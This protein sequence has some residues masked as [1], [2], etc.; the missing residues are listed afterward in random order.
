MIDDDR[1]RRPEDGLQ[2]GWKCSYVAVWTLFG[3]LGAVWVQLCCCLAVWELFGCSCIAVWTLLGAVWELFGCCLDAVRELS[4]ELFGCWSG[5]V[6]GTVWKLL[7]SCLDA[8]R[9]L[10]ESCSG[11]VL[12]LFRRVLVAPR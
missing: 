4:W 1:L 5:A 9:V 11:A 12:K 7:G 2:S 3:C 10:I 6:L 8:V